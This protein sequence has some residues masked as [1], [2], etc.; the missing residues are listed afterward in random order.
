MNN[1][2]STEKGI[3]VR[4]KIFNFIISY[5]TEHGYPPTVREIG[6]GVGLKST[7]SVQ[8]HMNRLLKEGR[9]KTDA[10]IGCPRAI[11]ISGYEFIKTENE[12]KEDK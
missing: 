12:Y 7:S 4:E 5:I 2:D 1:G 8:R 3:Y 10:G 9:I 6:D 11:R